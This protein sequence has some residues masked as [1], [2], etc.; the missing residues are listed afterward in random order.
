MSTKVKQLEANLQ[1]L[2]EK[3]LKLQNQLQVMEA[4]QQGAFNISSKMFNKLTMVEHFGILVPLNV[5]DIHLLLL[6]KEWVTRICSRCRHTR[7]FTADCLRL[8][9]GKTLFDQFKHCPFYFQSPKG[10]HSW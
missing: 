5:G 8:G 9:L 1:N 10:S 7:H 4:S 6:K 2:Q 3:K